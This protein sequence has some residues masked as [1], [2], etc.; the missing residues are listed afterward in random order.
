MQHRKRRNV[1]W[2][3]TARLSFCDLGQSEA[4]ESNH[5]LFPSPP[6]SK[7]S[8]KPITST[9][10]RPSPRETPARKG[11]GTGESSSGFTVHGVT[12]SGGK[13]CAAHDWARPPVPFPPTS[14]KQP[15]APRPP[16][17]H[18]PRHSFLR[19]F[20]VNR[21]D[22]NASFSSPNSRTQLTLSYPLPSTRRS[23]LSGQHPLPQSHQPAFHL[24]R[25]PADAPTCTSSQWLSH[26]RP[27]TSISAKL[28]EPA[29][30]S[31]NQVARHGRVSS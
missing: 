14:P 4:S 29:A 20:P 28:P 26:L 19:R 18:A 2:N 5:A 6:D 1:A 16:S 21:A 25:A 10:K 31:R 9:P 11:G 7:S 3:G 24:I 27:A 13:S 22:I 30:T 17:V 23:S 8:N 15:H 12:H